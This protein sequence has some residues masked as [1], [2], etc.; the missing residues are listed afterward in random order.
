MVCME[1]DVGVNNSGRVAS[2]GHLVIVSDLSDRAVWPGFTF[3]YAVAYMAY[4]GQLQG[5]WMAPTAAAYV[6]W[7]L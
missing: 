6:H 1:P 4:L 2:R 3:E 5:L 7:F